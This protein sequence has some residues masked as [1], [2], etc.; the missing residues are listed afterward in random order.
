M[1]TNTFL[2]TAAPFHEQGSAFGAATGQGLALLWGAGLSSRAALGAAHH[3]HSQAGQGTPVPSNGVG[4]VCGPWDLARRPGTAGGSRPLLAL[5][6]HRRAGVLPE[7]LRPLP[8]RRRGVGRPASIYRPVGG[9]APQRRRQ[10]GAVSRWCCAV[11]GTSPERRTG[12][13]HPEP[14][15]G[16][17]WRSTPRCAGAGRGG[18]GWAGRADRADRADSPFS[19]SLS[20]RC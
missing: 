4:P 11:L 1:Q 5:S 12:S 10:L 19:P 2:T 14:W 3:R 18:R 9:S 17:P 16:S 15:R 8:P 7:L 20:S 6:P 13:L